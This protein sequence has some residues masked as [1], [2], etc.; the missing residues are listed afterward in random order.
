M[1]LSYSDLHNWRKFRTKLGKRYRYMFY[2]KPLG[3]LTVCCLLRTKF[4]PILNFA[5]LSILY[6]VEPPVWGI[7][8]RGRMSVAQWAYE[9]GASEIEFKRFFSL[10]PIERKRRR[11]KRREEESFYWQWAEED[12][13][14]TKAPVLTLHSCVPKQFGIY[15]VFQK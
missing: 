6:I 10:E 9:F 8:G 12:E 3:Q 15:R 11:R 1:T 5:V 13:K 7:L 14:E 2:F 4:A